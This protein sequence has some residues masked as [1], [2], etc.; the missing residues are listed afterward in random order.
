MSK[1]KIIK[2][3]EGIYSVKISKN[4]SNNLGQ[5]SQTA[6]IRELRGNFD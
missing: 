2:F 6:I 1:V 4:V 5:I 3:S